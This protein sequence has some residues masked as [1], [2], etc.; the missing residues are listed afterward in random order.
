[1]DYCDWFD[2]YTVQTAAVDFRMSRGTG[3]TE[4]TIRRRAEQQMAESQQHTTSLSNN[5]GMDCCI[6]QE[7]WGK[8]HLV[9][10]YNILDI[11]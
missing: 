1:M 11:P 4:G 6:S 9:T 7:E 2:C 10:S 5:T 8:K 3:G